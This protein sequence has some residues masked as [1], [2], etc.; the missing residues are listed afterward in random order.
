MQFLSNID[1][2]N[3]AKVIN[4]PDPTSAQDVATK[5]YVDQ[6][7]QGLSWKDSVRVASTANVNTSSPGSSIDGISLTSGDRVLLKDQSTGSQNGVYIWNGAAVAMTRAADMDA[8]AE[9]EAAVV[10]VEEGTTN[11]GTT[12]VQTAVNVTLGTTSL[13]FTSFGTAAGS[14]SETTAGII[15]IAT[16]SEVDTGT[17]AVRAVP[18]AY[19]AGWSKRRRV[20][21][22]TVGDGSATQIDV[23]HNFGSFD[24]DVTLWRASGSRDR[25]FADTSMPDNNTVRFNFASAPTSGQFAYV[26]CMGGTA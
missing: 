24:L 12:W 10:R 5:A 6:F 3:Q 13:T 17:D 26:I 23:T 8:A 22:G 14:A 18:P 9:V 4:S 16:Q 2:N 21:T 25:V 15:E 20:K 7:I 19:L 1:L 11:A